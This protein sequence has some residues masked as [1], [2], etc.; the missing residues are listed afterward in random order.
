M[1]YYSFYKS[2]RIFFSN[3][4]RISAFN[5]E[6]TIK[7]SLLYSCSVT[8]SFT[9][10][11]ESGKR[12]MY[13]L[14]FFNDNWDIYILRIYFMSVTL[15]TILFCDD[16]QQVKRCLWIQCGH[17]AKLNYLSGYVS[18]LPNFLCQ[19]NRLIYVIHCIKHCRRKYPIVSSR[20]SLKSYLSLERD[21]VFI[22]G[23]L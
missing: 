21:L 3:L 14:S 17:P 2:W 7:V 10:I 13:Y 1:E 18:S 15:E 4:L 12:R 11:A 22:N 8:I 20:I 23:H 5:S 19:N 9:F 16:L 6:H